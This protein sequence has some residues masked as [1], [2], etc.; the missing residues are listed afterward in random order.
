MQDDMTGTD[1][2]RLSDVDFTVAD[3]EPD[4]RGWSVV[5]GSGR[6][7]GDVEDL[8]VDTAAMKVRYLELDLDDELDR[9]DKDQHVY[10]PIAS[11]DLDT[12]RKQVI[13]RDGN[14]TMLR[15]LVPT[16]S[17]DGSAPVDG[18]S[19]SHDDAARTT[20]DVR[21]LERAEEEVRIGKRA[22]QAG[23]V[24]VSKHVETEHVRDDVA[25]TREQVKIE[26]QPVADRQASAEIRASEEEIRIPL[27][28]EEV[29][30]EKRAVVKEEIVISKERVEKTQPVD[31]EVRK[32]KFD[33]TNER[34]RDGDE[35]VP[36]DSR[37]RS[38][39]S[40]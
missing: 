5:D 19:H 21:R 18:S 35:D 8:I 2:R 39:G 20:G 7:L 12:E 6:E 4:P 25:L 9:A 37:L 13:V 24:R 1:L 31:V 34:V 26:R 17:A 27:V 11:A 36:A 15:S 16:G 30:I 28:E 10:I 32:E 40:R 14:A 33:I 38:G 23:E 29:V 3:N 22:V